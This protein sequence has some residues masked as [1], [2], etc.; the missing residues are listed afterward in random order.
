MDG[1]NLLRRLR[2]V[3]DEESSGTWMDDRTSYDF[4]FEAAKQFVMQTGCLTNET[5]FK[6]VANQANYQLPTDFIK[7]YAKSTNNRYYVQFSGS[8]NDNNVL[9]RDYEDLDYNKYLHTYDT[10]QGT[11]TRN[12]TTFQD[13]GQDFSDW[14]TTSGNAAY[15]IT[16]TH[17]SGAVEWAYLG[18]DSTT[19][20]TNDTIA[21]YSD[22]ALSSGGWNGTSGT[23]SFYR[24]EQTSGQVTPDYF[25]IRD[26]QDK[27][28]QVTG[29]ATSAGDASAGECTL[30]DSAATFITSEYVTA[31]DIVHN[32][33]DGSD[34]V[35]LS[36]TS[37]TQL[38]CSL[39]GGTGNDWDV[40]D[41]YVIQPQSRQEI[42]FDPPPST[43]GYI[44]RVPYLARPAPVYSDYGVYDFRTH[45]ME[46]IIKYAAWLY[47][48]RDS[49][50]D[51]GDKLYL[52]WDKAVKQEAASLQP[53]IRR[54]RFN[55]N[56][57]AR[58][59]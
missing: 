46:A 3:L 49:E 58:R 28:T 26:K 24:I 44:V 23:P 18:D 30:T 43:A 31:G 7:L 6:T 10:Q 54:R 41:A 16:V 14:I 38:V 27:M 8:G 40:D 36:I 11:M 4:C 39:F 45:N 15:K 37:D 52:F 55:V 1:K 19:T 29:T 20:N 9:F 13:T 33:T 34:G 53:H 57:K 32:T 59:R 48:Y 42:F 35:I 21:V 50:P 12:A 2:E 25:A 51:F 56:L 5:E 17:T 22:L 47:K